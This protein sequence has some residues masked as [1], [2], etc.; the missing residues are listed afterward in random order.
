MQRVSERG[1]HHQFATNFHDQPRWPHLIPKISF[2]RSR[3]FSS[4]FSFILR[5]AILIFFLS[6]CIFHN[7]CLL[8]KKKKKYLLSKLRSVVHVARDATLTE[9]IRLVVCER[10]NNNV[11]WWTTDSCLVWRKPK[12]RWV[13]FTL[14]MLVAVEV[15]KKLDKCVFW[16][17]EP[18]YVTNNK[19]VSKWQ[20]Q[21]LCFMLPPFFLNI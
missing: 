9:P 19:R 5:F 11:F 6:N 13:L 16:V 8:F 3:I 2:S 7:I 15:R 21:R 14:V 17:T 12:C 20:K 18:F 10:V 4:D 1:A